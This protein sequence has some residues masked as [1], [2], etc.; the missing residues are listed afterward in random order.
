MQRVIS[1]AIVGI[2]AFLAVYFGNI[3]YYLLL[4]F[5]AV[6]G[7]YEIVLVLDKN[8]KSLLYLSMLFLS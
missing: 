2:V 3:P 4:S 8:F 5:F 6:Y 7:C 1:G